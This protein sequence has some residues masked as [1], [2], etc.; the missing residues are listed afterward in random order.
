M[1]ETLYLLLIFKVVIL[2]KTFSYCEKCHANHHYGS[3]HFVYVYD[4][5]SLRTHVPYQRSANCTVRSAL[6]A[7]RIPVV[8]HNTMYSH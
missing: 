4:I 5:R 8:Y 6:L 3:R 1:L 2:G 7:H